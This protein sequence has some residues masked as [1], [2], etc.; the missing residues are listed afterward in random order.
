[1][2]GQDFDRDR[3]IETGVAGFVDLAHPAGPD[4]REDFIRA[5]AHAGREGHGGGPD[6]TAK[7]GGRRNECEGK[8]GF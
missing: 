4:G 7:L 3:A 2:R 8:A 1:M 5:E 6:Y